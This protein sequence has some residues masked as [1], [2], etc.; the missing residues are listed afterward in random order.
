MSL[1]ALLTSKRTRTVLIGL[2]A[3]VALAITL[4]FR[5]ALGGDAM[6]YTALADGILHGN[7]WVNGQNEWRILLKGLPGLG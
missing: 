6:S 5:D 2:N 1:R 7:Y 3:L 4:A